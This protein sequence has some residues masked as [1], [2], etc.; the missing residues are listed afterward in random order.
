MNKTKNLVQKKKD[1]SFNIKD[2]SLGSRWIFL[3]YSWLRIDPFIFVTDSCD[4]LDL[5]YWFSHQGSTFDGLGD[6]SLRLRLQH[7]SSKMSFFEKNEK[8]TISMH[9]ERDFPPIFTTFISFGC[10]QFEPLKSSIKKRIFLIL[11]TFFL[12]LKF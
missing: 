7:I 12:I 1:R 9:Q 5:E 4:L 3:E 8:K 11:R 2:W 6:R 10:F